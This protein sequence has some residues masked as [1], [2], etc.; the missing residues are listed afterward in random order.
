M[1]RGGTADRGE[2]VRVDVF[3]KPNRKGKDEWYLVPIC[4]QQVM[5]KKAWPHPPI[6]SVVAYKDE[7]EWTEIGPEHKFCFSLY[8]RSY[9]EAIK[10]TRELFEGYFSGLDRSTGAISLSL[11][12]R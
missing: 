1:V 7:S 5:N 12:S 2:M 11:R 4:P 8:P 9:V 6:R 3:S 10:A